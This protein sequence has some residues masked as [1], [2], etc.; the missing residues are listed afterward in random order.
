MS[1]QGTRS[2][3]CGTYAGYQRHHRH[4]EYACV[5]CK[6]ANRLYHAKI[7]AEKPEFRA[8]EKRRQAAR[9]R[10]LARLSR[11]FPRTY[12]KYYAEELKVTS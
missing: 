6:E 12:R 10:A 4:G 8:E 5:D 7:R 9:D 2:T 1:E 3:A 11:K